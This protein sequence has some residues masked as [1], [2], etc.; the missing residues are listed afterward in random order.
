MNVEMKLSA[1]EIESLAERVT[2]GVVR[3]MQGETDV[4]ELLNVGAL[5]AYLKV[6]P[7]WVYRQVQ[8]KAIPFLKMGK[9][10]RFRK[11]II[12]EWVNTRHIP[13]WEIEEFR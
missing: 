3:T 4:S 8:Q 9:Y 6:N 2:V 1:Q 11:S 12:D 7:S 5:S 13:L 10:L